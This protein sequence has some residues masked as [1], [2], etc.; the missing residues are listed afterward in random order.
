MNN[1]QLATEVLKE[2]GGKANIESV[3]HCVTRLRFVLHDTGIPNK[4]TI[5]SLDGVISVVEQGGQYQIV[6]GNRVNDVYEAVLQQV[7][8]LKEDNTREKTKKSLFD[9]FTTTISGIFTP[10]LGAM[11]ASGTIKGI[12]T[13]LSVAGI[14]SETSGTYIVLYALSN[15][16]F[17]FMPI[18]LGASAA[19]YFKLNSYVGMLIGASLIYPTLLPYA[20]EGSLTFLA[21]P[22]NMMDYTSSVFPAIIAVWVAAKING[23]VQNWPL[24]DL[25][26]MVQPLIVLLVSVPLALLVVGP[27]ISNLSSLMAALVN[28]VYHFSP[29]LGGLVIGGPWILMV[30]FGLHWAFIPIFL[31]NMAMQGFDPVMGLLLANQMAMAGAVVAVGLRTKNDKTKA[32]AYSTGLTTLIGVSE[33]ALYGVLLPYKRPLIAAVIGG[34]LGGVIAGFTQTVQY[35]FG[36]SGLLG[37]PLIINPAGIDGG[38]YGGIASQAVGLVAAFLITYFWGI[39][40]P[41]KRKAVNSKESVD[42]KINFQEVVQGEVVP[43]TEVA[44]KVFSEGLMGQGKAVKPQSNTF[45]APFDGMVTAL[46]PTKHAIGLTSDQGVELLIHIGVDTVELEGKHFTSLV[47]A[48][49]AIKKGQPLIKA[50]LAAIQA[51]GYATITPVVVTNASAFEKIMN[52]KESLI[53]AN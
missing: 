13:I 34:S 51:E 9:Q 19:N 45:Y 22:V 37:I 10:A 12:L 18:L 31:N 43:L 6:L 11:A 47:E 32:L 35:S 24:K 7:G 25:R 26:F 8:E 3:T 33:P 29:V 14:L 15:A 49:Q 41:E 40:E 39:V 53:V 28:N 42:T 38:F 30:M 21:I 5:A 1:Q 4:E 48:N 16:F 44:D 20:T 50:D 27:I 36:G 52:E 46:F 17:Y 23:F 2:I